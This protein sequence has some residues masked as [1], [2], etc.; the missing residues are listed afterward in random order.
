MRGEGKRLALQRGRRPAHH[1]SVDQRLARIPD[2]N[3]ALLGGQRVVDQDQRA[4][5]QPLHFQAAGQLAHDLVEGIEAIALRGQLAVRLGQGLCAIRDQRLEVLGHPIDLVKELGIA[6]GDRCLAG[7]GHQEFDVLLIVRVFAL[8]ALYGDH[9][10][11]LFFPQDGH[12]QP[13]ERGVPDLFHAQL[14]QSLDDLVGNLQRL[15]RSG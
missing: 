12:A 15:A 14:V 13:G 11:R 10:Q 2:Q 9:A 6:H 7:N 4:V 3:V 1:G 8:I 5:E